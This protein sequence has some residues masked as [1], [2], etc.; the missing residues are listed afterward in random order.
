MYSYVF[1]TFALGSSDW[2]SHL[3]NITCWVHPTL[4]LR[5]ITED[6]NICPGH[7]N[8][9]PAFRRDSRIAKS[10]YSFV[11]SVRLSVCME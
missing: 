7:K 6:K 8:G 11:I 10:D 9:T 4:S 3:T 2:F 5:I 1:L